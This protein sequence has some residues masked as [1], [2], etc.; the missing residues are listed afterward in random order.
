MVDRTYVTRQSDRA[1]CSWT[2]GELWAAARLFGWKGGS[3]ALDC[4]MRETVHRS[5]KVEI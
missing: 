5:L 3:L 2:G 4:V 1:S